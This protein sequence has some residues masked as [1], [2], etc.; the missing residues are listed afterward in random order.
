MKILYVGLDVKPYIGGIE[1]FILKSVENID[2]NKYIIEFLAYKG[3]VPCFYDEF[4]NMGLQFRF[5]TKRKENY[6][7]NLRELKELLIEQKYDIVHCH[8]NSYS[9]IAPCIMA[10]KLG[11]KV[12]IHAHNAGCLQSKK[13]V[14]LHY[15]NKLRMPLEKVK[16]IA[17]SDLAGKWFFGKKSFDILNNGVETDKLQF[18]EKKRNQIRKEFEI[19]DEKVVLH[20]GAF[21]NQ[22]NHKRIIEIFKELV[23]KDTKVKLILVG[24]GDLRE[25]IASIVKE[26]GLEQK[27]IFTGNRTDIDAL[28]SAADVFLF[29]SFYEGFPIALIEAECSGLPCVVSDVITKEAQFDGVC[30]AV[31]LE[32]QN[33]EWVDLLLKAQASKDREKW[34]DIIKKAGLGIDTEIRQIEK[35]YDS[36]FGG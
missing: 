27:V 17:V 31:S 3:D 34:A 19:L 30:T 9:Y 20:V 8:M 13:A 10:I 4:S 28:L 7:R 25:E 26:K 29:P 5:I 2:R 23:Q 6:V 35:I 36:L 32:A 16:T 11:S 18:S 22:K 14:L 15:F 12:I 24:D 21:R 1:T 33:S